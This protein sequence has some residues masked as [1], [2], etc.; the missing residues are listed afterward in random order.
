M[1]QLWLYTNSTLDQWSLRQLQPLNCVDS[2]KK[3][4][5]CQPFLTSLWR[6]YA[7][8]AIGRGSHW[9]ANVQAMTQYQ[10]YPRSVISWP[11]TALK[12]LKIAIFW[13]DSVILWRHCDVTM[14]YWPTSVGHTQSPKTNPCHHTNSTP[15]GLGVHRLQSLHAVY[16]ANVSMLYRSLPDSAAIYVGVGVQKMCELSRFLKLLP[17]GQMLVA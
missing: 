12:A 8:W 17:V 10:Q 3:V 14:T 16:P 7:V 5:E 11:A 2:A 15:T 6:H 13:P 1:S 4:S 9:K